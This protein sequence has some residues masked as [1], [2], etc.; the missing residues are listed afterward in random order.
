MIQY[1]PD[2]ID[3]NFY[4]MEIKIDTEV[5]HGMVVVLMD[6]GH[7]PRFPK[8]I[9]FTVHGFINHTVNKK[10]TVSGSGLV[11]SKNRFLP[12]QI[13][14]KWLETAISNSAETVQAICTADNMAGLE[15]EAL[16]LRHQ[17]LRDSNISLS[18]RTILRVD[19]RSKP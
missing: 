15:K 10:V 3:Q 6:T 7:G 16:A 18:R 5:R 19:S 17:E 13:S 9:T 2:I 11:R 14:K 1:L 8:F 12:N 4:S